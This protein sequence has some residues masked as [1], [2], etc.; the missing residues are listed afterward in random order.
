VVRASLHY[1]TTDDELDR[2]AGLVAELAG[3]T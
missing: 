3:Y 1:I 2:F